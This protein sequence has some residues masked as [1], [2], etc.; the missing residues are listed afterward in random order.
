MMEQSSI[1]LY[2]V[3]STTALWLIA[4]VL[5]GMRFQEFLKNRVRL[6]A[7]VLDDSGGIKDEYMLEKQ[8][9]IL[10]GKSTPV[11]LV[12]IDFTGSRYAETIKEEHACFQR[13]GKFWYICS[14]AENG[15]VGLKQS[16]DD[17][18][19]KLRREVPYQIHHGDIVFISHEKIVI[20]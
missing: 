18:V 14:K 5:L 1:I 8:K 4:A 20:Q 17:V 11:N 16:G 6:K 10:I 9:E 15:M 2:L 12:H 3:L 7:L 13:Y 19:Y